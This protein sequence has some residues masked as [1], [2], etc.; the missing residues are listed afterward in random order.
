MAEPSPSVRVF[1]A[2]LHAAGNVLT[3]EHPG[4]QRPQLVNGPLRIHTSGS[5]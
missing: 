5:N 3:I 1:F 4:F 2:L